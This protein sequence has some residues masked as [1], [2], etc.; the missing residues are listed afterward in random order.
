MLGYQVGHTTGSSSS[1]KRCACNMHTN[2]P[3]TG[4]V[5][6]PDLTNAHLHSVN[7][8]QSQSKPCSSC[9]EWSLL[10][11]AARGCSRHIHLCQTVA[12]YTS[13]C[14]CKRLKEILQLAQAEQ[15]SCATLGLCLMS[16]S[17]ILNKSASR[18]INESLS[19]AHKMDSRCHKTCMQRT[20]TCMLQNWTFCGSARL[21]TPVWHVRG[22]LMQQQKALGCSC[23]MRF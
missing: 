10:H 16:K 6:G 4:W 13:N 8:R 18:L 15:S 19:E 14:A 5:P 3:A 17:F 9:Q 2:I 22:A 20:G 11:A 21:Q 23:T 1:L 12:R 7:R